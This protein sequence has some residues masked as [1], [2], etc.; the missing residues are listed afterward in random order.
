MQRSQKAWNPLSVNASRD[1]CFRDHLI[2]FNDCVLL[3]R[4]S[5]FET[6][7]EFWQRG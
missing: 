7:D 3:S 4:V 5:H 2:I 6:H 1:N